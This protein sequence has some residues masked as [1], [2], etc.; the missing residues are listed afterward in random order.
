MTVKQKVAEWDIDEFWFKLPEE[1]RNSFYLDL[2]EQLIR[3]IAIKV[4]FSTPDTLGE[5]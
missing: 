3:E 4:S 2:G 5:Q 1:P